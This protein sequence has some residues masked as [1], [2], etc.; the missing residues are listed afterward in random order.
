MLRKDSRAS[1][2]VAAAV[3]S[4][5]DPSRS[6]I[7]ESSKVTATNLILLTIERELTDS[8][9]IRQHLVTDPLFRTHRLH[10]YPDKSASSLL[11]TRHSPSQSVQKIR[12]DIILPIVD[13]IGMNQNSFGR[14]SLARADITA[15]CQ[16]L[17][18]AGAAV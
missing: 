7:T 17:V 8:C 16:Y 10:R 1:L 9:K 2:F 3:D 5:S 13:L 18:P 6:G 4:A 15:T 14:C 12:D 11:P